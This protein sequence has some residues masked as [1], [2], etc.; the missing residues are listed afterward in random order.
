MCLLLF[1]STAILAGYG[2][3]YITL[4]RPAVRKTSA[5]QN[6]A[7]RSSNNPPPLPARPTPGHI[8]YKY[9]VSTTSSNCVR[10]CVCAHAKIGD[11]TTLPFLLISALPAK[12]KYPLTKMALRYRGFPSFC[13]GQNGSPTAHACSVTFKLTLEKL[14]S[15]P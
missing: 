3:H 6:P 14:Y 15:R 5:P 4:C 12:N 9:V 1:M 10:L 8:L 13:L 7:G 2:Y 11:F